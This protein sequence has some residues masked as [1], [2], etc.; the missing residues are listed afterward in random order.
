LDAHREGN[1]LDSTTGIEERYDIERVLGQGSAG[2]VYRVRDRETGER[3]ALK[4]LLRV[5]SRSVQLLK[6]EFR[7]LAD[8]HHPNL[9]KLY[10][11]G[12]SHDAWFITMEY[13]RG[14]DLLTYLNTSLDSLTSQAPGVPANQN[15]SYI[16][17]AL[18]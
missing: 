14:G 3:L 18:V 16:V 17:I 2:I 12:R 5:D 8:L 7:S 6:H 13:L 11:L 10:D 4:K 9:V 15:S 1:I